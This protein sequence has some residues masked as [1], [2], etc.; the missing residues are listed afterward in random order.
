[1]RA[2]VLLLRSFFFAL[3]L[4][5]PARALADKV[6]VLPFTSVGQATSADLTAARD[7]TKAAALAKGHIL[8]TDSEMLAAQMSTKDGSADTSEE[9][10]AAGRASGAAWTVAGRVDPKEGGY[11]LELEVCQVDSGR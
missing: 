1:M 8:A 9:Y 6:A 2:L 4:L 7:A 3:V 11:R 5:V 10:R